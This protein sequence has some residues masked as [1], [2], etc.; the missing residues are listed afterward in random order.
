M[1]DQ[2]FDPIP[3]SDMVLI[4]AGTFTMGDCLDGYSSAVPLHNVYVSAFY[5]DKHELTNDTMVAVLQWAN[6][7]G[8]IQVT[9]GAVLNSEGNQQNLLAL[10]SPFCRIIWD[11]ARFQVKAEKGVG[12]PCVAV[13]WY[14]AVAFC[15][16]RSQMESRT[17]CYNLSDWSCNWLANGYRLPTEAEWEKAARG[18]ATGRRFPWPDSDTTSHGRANYFGYPASSGGYAYDLAP[19]GFHPTFAIGEEPYT[20]PVGFFKDNA[21]GYGLYDMAGN[22]WEWCWDWYDGNWYTNVAATACDTRGPTGPLSDRVLHGGSWMDVAEFTRCGIRC[23]V[24]PS[25]SNERFGFR[26]AMGA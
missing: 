1:T 17:A 19:M 20:S 25:V 8:K 26:C 14:G 3:A 6:Q 18:G 5:I 23:H 15:N 22:V 21:N 16:Y 9:S 13:S 4:P 7:Q 10:H 24:A 11:G 2:V 12:Y